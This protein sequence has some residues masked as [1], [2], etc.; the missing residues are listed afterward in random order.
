MNPN[1]TDS[2]IKRLS[3]EAVEQ[4]KRKDAPDPRCPGLLVTVQRRRHR[5]LGVS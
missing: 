5:G 4:G 2:Y 3:R 1:L